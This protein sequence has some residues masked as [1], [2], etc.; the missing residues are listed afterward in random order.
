M[1]KMPHMRRPCSDCPFRK[2]TLEGWLGGERMTEILDADSFVCH[3]KPS[4]QCAGH[5]LLMDGDNA[6][7]QLASRLR[8][9]LGI[10]GRELVFDT[11]ADCIDHHDKQHD[12]IKRHAD[13]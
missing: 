3:K 8:I 7:V 5:M 9:P 4:R 1:K 13:P 6:Y 12:A 2:D 10:S 11:Q